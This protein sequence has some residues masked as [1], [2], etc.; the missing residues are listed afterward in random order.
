M[1]PISAELAHRPS[2]VS[3]IPG[4]PPSPNVPGYYLRPRAGGFVAHVCAS[5][6]ALRS[7]RRLVPMVLRG[8]GIVAED[9]DNAQLVVSE[10]VGNSVR[11]C[12]DHV[13]VV[14]EVYAASY[15]VAVNVHDP[16]P[17]LSALPRRGTVP[18]DS[19]VAESGRGLG[20]LDLLAPGWQ[21]RRSSIGKQVRCRVPA[22]REPS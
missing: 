5:G 15:G 22:R 2:G 14:V 3:G 9:V 11:A 6:A 8:H 10:L 13:P 21:V 18:L 1:H 4:V 19:A 16:D 20:L 12:G 7:V 17:D